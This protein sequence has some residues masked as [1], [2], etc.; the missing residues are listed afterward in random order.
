MKLSSAHTHLCRQS[1]LNGNAFSGREIEYDTRVDTQFGVLLDVHMVPD[2]KWTI[3]NGQPGVD[4]YQATAERCTWWMAA[5]KQKQT[6]DKQ[7]G[8][9]SKPPVEVIEKVMHH[10]DSLEISSSLWTRRSSCVLPSYP[11]A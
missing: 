2:V 5:N 3:R 6:D 4:V 7:T 9:D 10:G 1:T 8:S 11:R